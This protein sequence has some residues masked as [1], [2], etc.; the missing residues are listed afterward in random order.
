MKHVFYTGM[1]T[2]AQVDMNRHMRHSAYA[3]FAA[4]ARILMLES[5]GLPEMEF[6]KNTIGPI[7]FREEILYRREA[8][9]NDEIR[10]TCLLTKSREDA[11]R[12]SLKHQLYRQDDVLVAELNV[13]GSWI[14]MKKRK[15]AVLP[16]DFAT[17]FLSIPKSDDFELEI[18]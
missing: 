3:D 6:V 13:D 4:Q 17:K 8:K 14:D 12:W 11:T 7:L 2:W 16:T 18:I 5:I 1:V 15:L 9:L 10:V